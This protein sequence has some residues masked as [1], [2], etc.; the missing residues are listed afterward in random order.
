MISDEMVEKALRSVPGRRRLRAGG[1]VDAVRLTDGGLLT[2]EIVRVVLEA[3]LSAPE[4]GAEPF[5]WHW[6]VAINGTNYPIWVLSH[7]RPTG[8]PDA[9]TPLFLRPQAEATRPA[10]EAEPVGYVTV[11]KG[12]RPETALDMLRLGPLGEGRHNL[13][14]TPLPPS[15]TGA[16]EREWL[17]FAKHRNWSIRLAY[18]DDEGEEGYW[19]VFEE[20]GNLNDRIWDEIGK[21]E[22]PLAALSRA[23]SSTTKGGE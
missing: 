6:K 9:A 18:P 19:A 8:A 14:A 7:E 20:S 21:G 23:L 17:E 2:S 1:A 4:S 10:L 5:A 16:M 3:A 13:Y 15:P 12:K 22:T 11:A